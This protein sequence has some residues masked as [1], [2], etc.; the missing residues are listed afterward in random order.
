MVVSIM[1]HKTTDSG[2][3]LE[4]KN[5]HKFNIVCFNLSCYTL[6]KCEVY[7][8]EWSQSKPSKFAIFFISKTNIVVLGCYLMTALTLCQHRLVHSLEENIKKQ[9]MEKAKILFSKHVT[10]EAFQWVIGLFHQAYM[11]YF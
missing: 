3:T 11:H 7:V 4:L 8:D 9:E 1:F 10:V 6:Q 5:H 2:F